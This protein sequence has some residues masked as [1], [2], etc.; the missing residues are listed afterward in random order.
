VQT[1]VALEMTA[2]LIE[3]I[4][5]RTSHDNAESLNLFLWIMRMSAPFS[6]VDGTMFFPCMRLPQL[7]FS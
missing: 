1:N 5:P 2:D 6:E 4:N 7:M 3:G